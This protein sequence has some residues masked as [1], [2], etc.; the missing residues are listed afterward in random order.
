[1]F[2]DFYDGSKMDYSKFLSALVDNSLNDRREN[3]V[4]EAFKIIDVENCGVVNLTEIKSLFNS[5]NSPLY[6]KDTWPKKIFIII[7]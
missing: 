1:M 6:V 4:K 7:L 3:I 2:S 5:K